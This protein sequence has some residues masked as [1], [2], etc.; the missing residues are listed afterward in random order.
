LFT[1]DIL[2]Y[3]VF[4]IL[5]FRRRMTFEHLKIAFPDRTFKER[6]RI[7]LESYKN[8]G[9]TLIE[10]S[11]VQF[12][13]QNWIEKNVEF[14]GLENLREARK[15]DKGVCLATLHL[16]SGDLALCLL[17]K[18]GVPINL[19]S[20]HFKSDWLNNIWFGMRKKIGIRFTPE[21]K[22]SFQIL[23]AL[24]NKD[25][26]VFVIDQFMGPPVGVKTNFFGRETGTAAGLAL[27]AI[28]SGAPVLPAYCYRRK[29]GKIVVGF[30]PIIP[31]KVTGDM[32]FDLER[33]TQIFTEWVEKIIRIFPD[34]W[35]WLHRRWKVF[36]VRLR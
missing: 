5:R 16:G 8:M 6:K 18:I 2:A 10:Y 28:R 27:F 33:N 21:E 4:Y 1:A 20:K 24:K 9:R 13:E 34:Q 36:E 29:D 26:V 25:V 14:V 32:K 22:S 30:D 15:K 17:A 7:A 3:F 31:L 35:L 19:I 23:R 11:H 12:L